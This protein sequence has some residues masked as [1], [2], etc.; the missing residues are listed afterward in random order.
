MTGHRRAV[1]AAGSLVSVVIV[2]GLA[3]VV[4]LDAAMRGIFGSPITKVLPLVQYWFM[5]AIAFLGYVVAQLAD[6]HLH[7]DLLFDRLRPAGRRIVG[8]LGLVISG[9]AALL[10]AYHSWG[11]AREASLTGET[12]PVSGLPTWPMTFG[13]PVALGLLG[14]LFLLA[15]WR[16]VFRGPAA[17]AADAENGS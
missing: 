11:Y 3:V 16:A 12:D 5:P 4:V 7:V 6:R 14:V 1:S 17:P 13:A 9:I 8:G 2:V 15:A 10:I